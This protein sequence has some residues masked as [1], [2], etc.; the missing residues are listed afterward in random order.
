[1]TI[2]TEKT[3]MGRVA[4][5]VELVNHVDAVAAQIGALPADK[6]RRLKIDGIVDT[7]ASHLVIPKSV[8]D[9]LGVP[10]IGETGV[11]YADA[12]RAARKIV[13]DVEVHLLSRSGIFKAIVEPDRTDALIGAIVLEDMD[14][15]VDCREQKLVP[16]DPD[17]ILSEA[18]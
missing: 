16:R 4:A 18:E 8:A 2:A 5:Q 7:G 9:A 10:I 17:R 11:R 3:E 14:F 6:V 12:R 1:M 13:T 15:I